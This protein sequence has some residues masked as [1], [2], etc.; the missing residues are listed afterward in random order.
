MRD[1]KPNAERQLSRRE[2]ERAPRDL[3]YDGRQAEQRALVS[4]SRH[5]RSRHGDSPYAQ[6]SS[7]LV[8]HERPY[9][10]EGYGHLTH[11]PV[12]SERDVESTRDYR[13]GYT[14][15]PRPE[16]S[17]EDIKDSL[18]TLY[19]NV[20]KGLIFLSAFKKEFDQDIL[21]VKAYAEEED[22]A[23]LWVDKVNF[24]NELGDPAQR[25]I[26]QGK[27]K[28]G[29]VPRFR[30]IANQLNASLV[31][32]ATNSGSSRS[33]QLKSVGKKLASAKDEVYHLLRT[34]SS[35]VESVDPLLTELEMLAVL[36]E[37]NGASKALI[38]GGAASEGD[39]RDQRQQ[40]VDSGYGGSIGGQA[41]QSGQ[42]DQGD[43][44]GHN[45]NGSED[46]N[47]QECEQAAGS[48]GGD[49]TEGDV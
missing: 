5:E 25:Q 23:Y 40:S 42:S 43:E 7:S 14:N 48:V 13:G 3:A 47:G 18:S 12:R 2:P 30:D 31:V 49:N 36:L 10:E 46:H 37:R 22:L 33:S 6:L 35:S 9:N 4:H 41:A 1:E 32:A 29:Q 11:R 20:K 28:N 15:S 17:P 26:A 27:A 38:N 21:R 24:S 39:T 45:E 44:Q 19:H 34:A 8:K 16:V